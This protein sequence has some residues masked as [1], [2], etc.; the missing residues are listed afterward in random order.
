MIGAGPRTHGGGLSRLAIAASAALLVAGG[1]ASLPTVG[2]PQSFDMS[3]PAANSIPQTGF[4]PQQDSSP[5]QLITDFL[6][7]CAAGSDDD[8]ATA[9]EYL[10]PDVA[11]RWQ[12]GVGVLIYPADETPQ[13]HQEV[14]SP[15]QDAISGGATPAVPEVSTGQESQAQ[16]ILQTHLLGSIDETGVL[17]DAAGAM[18]QVQFGLA[19]DPQGQW[20]ISQLDDGIVLSQYTFLSSYQQ[21]NLYFLTVD[22]ESLVPDPRWFPRKRLSSHLVQG[23]LAGPSET[24][25][26]AVYSALNETLRLPTQGVEQ[27]DQVAT[28]QLVGELPA[29]DQVRQKLSWQVTATLEQVAG[30]KQV[31][32]EVGAVELDSVPAGVGPSYELNSAV[33]V[34]SGTIVAGDDSNWRTVVPADQAGESPAYPAR[35]PVT[36]PTLAWLVGDSQLRIGGPDGA[37]HSLDLPEATPPSVDRWGWTWTS[38]GGAV[39][40][41]DASGTRVDLP[42]QGL[43]Q[44]QEG[45]GVAKAA[46]AADGVRLLLLVRTDAGLSIRTAVVVRDEQGMPQSI[47]KIETLS[48]ATGTILDAVWSGGTVVVLGDGGDEGTVLT[49]IPMGGFV[50]TIKGPAGAVKVAAGAESDSIYLQTSDGTVFRRMASL[51]N[52]TDGG[53][54]DISFPG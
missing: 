47:D 14:G 12:A 15:E 8:Y 25:R 48:Q 37:I 30:I 45:P 10:L 13:I 29:G 5:A 3:R 26:P 41:F 49:V 38:I 35:G 7:A 36:R 51:W 53:V 39:A 6:R 16:V 40:A 21:A 11:A 52:E 34:Q 54:K 46:I 42:L 31:R 27:Q 19:R 50:Q 28:V 32:V 9:K 18:A 1:C 43:G 24:L 4:G 22:Q 17:T 2:Q 20:R 44:G 23:L 33:G